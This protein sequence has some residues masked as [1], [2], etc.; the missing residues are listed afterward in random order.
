MK[1]VHCFLLGLVL[2]PGIIS[3]D[4]YPAVYRW[5][6]YNDPAPP[7]YLTKEAACLSKAEYFSNLYKN[8]FCGQVRISG[9]TTG[10]LPMCQKKVKSLINPVC[11]WYDGVGVNGA[12]TC[13]SGGTISGTNCKNAPACT[14]PKTRNPAT[15]L[16]ELP[17]SYGGS[18]LDIGNPIN[19]A[20]GNKRLHETDV[21]AIG[22]GLPF[23]RY[24]HSHATS[25]QYEL[26][27]GWFHT[28]M[29]S[30]QSPPSGNTSTVYRE[31][32]R[33]Y[34]F[35]LNSGFWLPDND[36]SDQLV[37]LTNSAN[38]RTGWRFTTTKGSEE[39]YDAAGKLTNIEGRSGFK[40]RL[41]Y[42]DSDT[43]AAIAPMP[44]LLITVADSYGRTIHFTYD[45]K[46]RIITM[47]VPDNRSYHY[48]YDANNNLVSVT[49]PD[50][51]FADLTDNPKK[52][53]IY[54]ELANTANVN[55]PNALTGIVDE[56]G[57]RY[58]TYRYDVS[59]RAISTEH[60]GGVEKYQLSYGSNNTTVTDPLNSVFTKQ[61]Q[62][63]L[64][65]AK[66]TSQTQP[67]GSGCAASSS[68]L[69]YDAN[70]NVA[71]R[72]DF[73]G[74][75]TDYVY[76][77][78]R[79]L[80]TSRTEGLTATG[81]QTPE[82]R[83]ITTQWHP[84]FR[85]PVKITEPGLE[86]TFQYNAQGQVTDKTLKDLTTQRSR[87][88]HTNYTY[89]IDGLL[90]RKVE[91]GPRTDVA[92]VTVYDYY[93]PDAACTGGHFG[94]RGQLQKITRPLGHLTQFSRYSA[95]GQL[96]E[97]ID[98][99][100][101]VTRLTYDPRQRLVSM[102][103][104]NEVTSFQYDPVGQLT[105]IGWPGGAALNYHYDD[106]HRLIE[107]TDQ[108]NNRRT[109]TLDNKGNRLKEEVYDPSGQLAHSESRVY[110]ALSRLQN[111][112]QAP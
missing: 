87:H 63:I 46:G 104:G 7:D 89:S 74:H 30:I 91:D 29:K 2:F 92:D 33:S 32:G 48:A 12:L 98:A 77:L 40:Q 60:A 14:P 25:H 6:G 68:N 61:F 26:G 51:T 39:L 90:L 31:D 67:A 83:T 95:N 66:L 15:G 45:T 27:S 59:G 9:L 79:N 57:V 54:G 78:T 82:T 86:T 50:E 34:N 76:D 53:Y 8:N 75:R 85:L 56:N 65:V 38:E 37:E 49:Y 106:A 73:N 102:A 20:I 47:T 100:G 97:I 88:W 21:S 62:V 10:G 17:K 43:S 112:I 44:G 103:V 19:A 41:T 52:T 1:S 81:A 4:T 72:M 110:D 69:G 84:V 71:Y 55:Q 58:A 3:A 11:N 99:N 111:R 18:C 96:E 23:E 105:H 94:C 5:Y 42:S 36:V 16:C 70:G 35:T 108:N 107:V 28:Y 64:G 22:H 24:Y 101:L 93:P 13:P 109:Y 80:E